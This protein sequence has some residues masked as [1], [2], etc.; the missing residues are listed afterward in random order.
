MKIPGNGWGTGNEP[1]PSP[2]N[3]VPLDGDPATDEN[4]GE[5]IDWLQV[6]QSPS[7][8]TKKITPVRHYS[9]TYKIIPVQ[10]R[11]VVWGA[12]RPELLITETLAFH[13]RRTEKMP[14]RP[15]RTGW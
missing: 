13:D 9:T 3:F 5:R 2:A 7:P 10:T 1:L 6:S 8:N 4:K 14:S 15:I 11:G 12:E